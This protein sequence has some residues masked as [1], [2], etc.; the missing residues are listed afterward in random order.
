MPPRKFHIKV[1]DERFSVF[2][3]IEIL[4][5][6]GFVFSSHRYKTIV[7]IRDE[8]PGAPNWR[9]LKI[10]C[11]HECRMVLHGGAFIEVDS[12]PIS[13]DAFVK[14]VLPTW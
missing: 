12:T 3:M 4:F 8:W 14:E 6:Y 11:D 2:E 13:F 7:E 5:K 10:G 9:N 1:A